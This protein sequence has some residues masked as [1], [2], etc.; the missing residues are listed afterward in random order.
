MTT[1]LL[2]ILLFFVI[3]PLLRG[4]IAVYRA[5]RQA[6][7]MFNMFTGRGQSS[8]GHSNAGN[9]QADTASR[10]KKKKIDPSVGEYVEFE[11]IHTTATA[12]SQS[13]R[14]TTTTEIEQ[15]IVDAEWEDIP[16]S[17]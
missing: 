3:L 5:Q 11:E 9:R 8:G 12:S 2:L 15:Q 14:S 6:R 16:N 1:I 4:A 13:G 7:E 17:K 10:Q